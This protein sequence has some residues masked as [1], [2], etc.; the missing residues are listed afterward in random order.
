MVSASL[1]EP[2]GLGQGVTPKLGD[3]AAPSAAE[4]ADQSQIQQLEQ[5]TDA[6]LKESEIIKNL[7]RELMEQSHG[8]AH[9]EAAHARGQADVMRASAEAAKNELQAARANSRDGR[10]HLS[11]RKL[12]ALGT[13]ISVATRH[14]TQEKAALEK[15]V[16]EYRAHA[17]ASVEEA[18]S[19]PSAAH[20]VIKTVK[21]VTHVS[22]AA[23]VG[24]PVFT[25]T[26]L[27]SFDGAMRR[28]T[29]AATHVAD[30]LSH[31]WNR[32]THAAAKAADSFM[33]SH[34]VKSAM[35]L[36]N[37]AWSNVKQVG[38]AVVDGVGEFIESPILTTKKAAKLAAEK[39][40][41]A[42]DKVLEVAVEAKNGAKRLANEYVV[43]PATKAADAV[44]AGAKR[45]YHSAGEAKDKVVDY[46]AAK[47]AKAKQFA[48]NLLPFGEKAPTMGGEA[49]KPKPVPVAKAGPA[50]SKIEALG[51]MARA[52]KQSATCTLSL[53]LA[54]QPASPALARV[55]KNVPKTNEIGSISAIIGA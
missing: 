37:A 54:C 27:F 52:L 14:G 30:S 42:A 34:P 16:A 43:Q 5:Q 39:I 18:K 22:T 49:A 4:V 12:S 10:C 33:E 55:P 24:A 3:S 21:Q 9:N 25:P 8:E 35:K 47:L 31:H 7:G 44:V 13:D 40:E 20:I 1:I 6:L 26:P 11:A 23:V 28:A 15:A 41:I 48:G 32:A 36:G 38:A 50:T 51:A 19:K 29:N 45:A 17:A 46:A 53:G 2:A